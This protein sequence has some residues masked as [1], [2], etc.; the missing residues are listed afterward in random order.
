M[1]HPNYR[2]DIDGLRAIA[3]LSVVGF[4]AFPSWVKGGFIG[5]DIFFVISGFL[6]S[7]IIVGSLDR[8]SFSFIEFYGRR[9]RR[10][11]P[12]LLL[13]LLASL[14]VGWFVL[15]P[16]DYKQ[17][18]KHI[19][20]GAGFA[21]NFLLWQESGY[22]DNAAETK[23]L[24]HLWSLGIEE[25]FYIAWPLL[26]WLAWRGGFNLLTVT[27]AIAGISFVL[28]LGKVGSD[29]VAAFYSPQTRVWELGGGA[30]LA[31]VTLHKQNI[32]PKLTHKLDIWLGKIIYEKAPEANGETL[33]NFQSVL[34]AILITTGV[35]VINKERHFPGW[36]ALLPTIGA[37]L[38]ISA[39]AQAWLNRVVLSN[40]VLVWFG[41]ISFPLYL[42][43]WPL[44]SFTR[45]V[46]SGMPSRE[47]RIAAVFISIALAWLTYILIE[48]PIRF[49]EHRKRKT[50]ALFALMITAGY[51]GYY[52]YERD[53]LGFRF[54]KIVQDLFQYKYDYSK[55]YREDSCFVDFNKGQSYSTF[56]AKC[57][58][59]LAEEEKPTLVLWGDSHAAHLYPGFKAYFGDRFNILQR[60]SGGC[61]PL[62]DWGRASCIEVNRKIFEFIREEKP[63]KVV[64]A[65]WWAQGYSLDKIEET[66]VALQKTGVKDIALIGPVPQWIDSLSKQLYLRV[67]SDM[68]HQVPERMNFGL[69]RDVFGLDARLSELAGRLQVAY[70]S[71]IAI[72]CNDGGCITRLGETGD[73]LTAK[74]STHLTE[75]S[76]RFLV[77]QFPKSTKTF[78]PETRNNMK[79][80]LS[81]SN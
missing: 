23:P 65:A 54:E 59:S 21:S 66:I 79:S 24:L 47:M 41:L 76:S 16:D 11:F 22:F 52:C 6:I 60:T 17:L 13:V 35:L 62:F 12:A 80:S 61:P 71:P 78:V 19:V 56:I 68:F 32:F 40:R 46:E 28:S 48:K 25:Q 38:I 31:N 1:T 7:T 9:I 57:K 50:I 39:G 30:L 53:G 26:L 75:V 77:S 33:C 37:A 14:A 8:N 73:T 55:V 70:V 5:V 27:I 69:N 36:W 67:K 63:S 45:I 44:L 43:H 4:H 34:G 51:A 15:L 20:G 10:I 74:D 29:A 42:W 81:E 64:V 49:G 18:G 3:V 2:A 72:L 58:S